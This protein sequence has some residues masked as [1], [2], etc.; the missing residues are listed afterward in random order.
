MSQV[1]QKLYVKDRHQEVTAG[2][3][4][5]FKVMYEIV[6]AIVLKKTSLCCVFSVAYN[7]HTTDRRAHK[8]FSHVHMY[9]YA[10]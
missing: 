7:F 3:K 4:Y 2:T 8:G 5:L 10:A 6:F 9:I 1:V